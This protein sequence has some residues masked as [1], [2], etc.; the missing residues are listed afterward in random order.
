MNLPT[1]IPSNAAT[2]IQTV[3]TM[4]IVLM[5]STIFDFLVRISHQTENRVATENEAA[6]NRNVH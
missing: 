2:T 4:A 3:A 1:A 6:K 5:T